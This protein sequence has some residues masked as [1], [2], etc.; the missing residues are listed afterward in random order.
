MRI[1]GGS[2]RGRRLAAPP[3]DA[4]RPTSDRARES[5]FNRL[6]HGAFSADG[7]SSVAGATVL[8]ACCGTGALGLEA[9]SRG[10]R[11]ALFIDRDADAI[12]CVK[13]NIAALGLDEAA[14]VF[15]MDATRPRAAPQAAGLVFLDAPY[16]LDIGG[17][18]LSAL[19]AQGWIA[20]GALCIGESVSTDDA[21][22]APAGFSR[23]DTRTYGKA[24][25][26]CFRFA[27][28]G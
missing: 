28:A 27:D 21:P 11:Y 13:D 3:G 23:L 15:R 17:A 24:R 10:A 18:A 22:D 26:T 16:A 20:A 19:A 5:L 4:I 25:F 9:L 6:V 1:V 14:S 7:T 8:D 2:L 12:A